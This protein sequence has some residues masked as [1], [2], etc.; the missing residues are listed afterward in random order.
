M[1]ATAYNA[2]TAY[3]QLLPSLKGFASKL[4][5]QLAE[6]KETVS[7]GVKADTSLLAEEIRAA[8]T[9]AAE[10]VRIDIPMGVDPTGLRSEIEA[11][12]ETATA[13]LRVD[14]GIGVDDTG[15]RTRLETAISNASSGLSA[16]I[17]VDFD[18]EDLRARLAAVTGLKVR[19]ELDP[20]I[21][22]LRALL[23]ALPPIDVRVDL[24]PDLAALRAQL[25]AAN[26]ST[27]LRVDVDKDGSG[28]SAAGGLSRILKIATAAVAAL[29][30]SGPAFLAPLISALVA[31]AGAAGLLP[32]A[33]AAAG[34]SF[35]AIKIGVSGVGDA[36]KALGA[37]QEASGA[38][39]S[40]NAAQQAAAAKAI[41]DAARG[42]EDAQ[43]QAD[44]TAVDGARQVQDARQG[45][46]DAMLAS[47]ERVAAAE[48]RVVQAQRTRRFAQEDLTRAIRDAKEAQE[49]LTLSLSGAALSEE[50]AL[51]GLER[52]RERLAAM[53]A[54][55]TALD[56]KEA[57]LAV[58]QA[59]QAVR[60]TAERHVDL[61][62]ESAESAR[63]GIA[64][65]R[66]V[67]DANRQ[68]TDANRG[69]YDAESEL[70]QARMEGARDVQDAN[71]QLALA[72]E[73]AA[74]AN[75]DAARAVQRAQE[76]L[77]E[78][79][80]DTGGAADAAGD[81]AAAALAKLAPAAR[82]YVAAI[83]ALRP[84]WDSLK[85]DVQQALFQGLGASI[86]QLANAQLP[87]LASGLSGIAAGFNAAARE[88]F[89]FL[90][91]SGAVADVKQILADSKVSTDAWAMSLVPISAMFLDIAAVGAPIL[92]RLSEG[93]LAATERAAAFIETA[94][95]N[96]DLARWIEGGLQALRD[97]GEFL[98]NIAG[99]IGAVFDAMKT[100]GTS[101]MDTLILVTGEME[102]FLKSP[103]GQEFLVTFFSTL[104]G[105][106]QA[107][108]PGIQA[109]ATG[110]AQ[111]FVAFA[112]A[113]QPIA[114]AISAVLDA[115]SPLLPVVAEIAGFLG[116][117][118]AEAIIAL[119]P[120]LR[121]IADVVSTVL[122]TAF[123]ALKPVFVIIVEA[124][125]EMAPVLSEIARG[126]GDLLVAAIEAIA[127]ILPPLAD[128]FFRIMEALLP[129]LPVLVEFAAQLID[130]LAPILPQLTDLFI[131]VIDEAI[132]P[133]IPPLLRL[134]QELFPMLLW[135]I[136]LLLPI[137]VWLVSKFVDD[138]VW[139]VEN[140]V[141][142]A[143]EALT[144]VFETIRT[145]WSDVGA[146][147]AAKWLEFQIVAEATFYQIKWTIERIWD[148]IKTKVFETWT[149]IK[150]WFDEKWA[151]FR[152][153]WDGF[154]QGVRD[155][156]FTKWAEIKAD[157]TAAWETIRGF[158][159]ERLAEFTE[160]WSMIW[161]GIRD[162]FGVT[163]VIIRD[164]AVNAWNGIAAF[165]GDAFARFTEFFSGVW[166]NI[167][168]FFAGVWVG[169][170]DT[171]VNA[172]NGIQAFFGG[173][174]AGFAAFFADTWNGIVSN[175]ST[176]WS[177][178]TDIA[179]QVW[180]NV[181]RGFVDGVN[182]VI[183]IINGF[184]G[185]INQVAGM[186]GFTINLGVPELAYAVGGP[187]PANVPVAGR[188]Q[189]TAFATGGA[190]PGYAPGRDTIP[191]MLSPGEY[192]I[193]PEAARVIGLDW[194]DQLN[195]AH[196]ARFATGGMVGDADRS[197]L[198]PPR[199]ALREM[200]ARRIVDGADHDGPGTLRSGFGGVRPHVA[201][202]GHF[203]RSKFGV[204]TVGGIG[205][206][207]GPS[208]HP[209]G[210]ALDFMTYDDTAKG[211]ALSN[212]VVSNAKH[213]A[214]KY[215]IWK[216][217]INSGG[218]WKGMED[219]GSVTANHFD[220]P[221]LSFLDLPGTGKDF[222]GGGAGWDP[223]G[224]IIRALLAPL[225][226]TLDAQK[227]DGAL[228]QKV[229]AGV[230]GKVLDH[231]IG[232]ADTQDGMGAGGG[233]PG[234]GAIRDQVRA[235]ANR[236]GWGGGPQWTAL[237][238]LV[239]KESSWDPN[240]QNPT[241]TAFG[242]F[243]FLNSTWGTVGATKTSNPG[244]QAEAGLRY[245]Q[246]RYR[247][248][249]GA[250][251]FHNRNNYYDEGGVA[252]GRGIMLKNVLS[253]ERVLSPR[254]NVAFE[255]LVSAATGGYRRTAQSAIG[256]DL[257]NA[258]R[259]AGGPLIGSLTVQA[260]DNASAKDI[261]DEAM[262]AARTEA[263]SGRYHR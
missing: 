195:R 45:V 41:R 201:Q 203:L 239:Q 164:T 113:I 135:A 208:D 263:R 161:T 29:G 56:Y 213:L 27:G 59:E 182:G 206:R 150:T 130:S 117:Y 23:A 151:E 51:L 234:S 90:S 26:L 84:A 116:I 42:V 61:Q 140:I 108:M 216:Q 28:R 105:A 209:R 159:A 62:Q 12:L 225:R 53:P 165:F 100:A 162:F 226:G 43:R 1:A 65:A 173:A 39:A 230:F 157:V 106:V 16:S 197:G 163:W 148:E 218:G 259:A 253:P 146:W 58:R 37:A 102:R 155:W 131:R 54:D 5:T 30:A 121:T 31:S 172:W 111:A 14:T 86:S 185:V 107:L 47:N 36:F 211:D 3:V 128:A 48:Q 73:S 247:T 120:F 81:K 134:A 136:E 49:D 11:A 66:G 87:G 207:S 79:Y 191:A 25:A 93:W 196:V 176:I 200:E 21:A 99:S 72:Q 94:R 246:Q 187:V 240:A 85:M 80:A 180:E 261:I 229:V 76:A 198:L 77:A 183:R 55:S 178:I 242:L 125:R 8:A 74:Q 171:A 241:S 214:L 143:I 132:L 243:Q 91:S 255:Q 168:M 228:P 194:L 32:A 179:R 212:Y 257:L 96:G 192:V 17:N 119:M 142:P 46:A 237:E 24:N 112:P 166:N 6:V 118:L 19:V 35:A 44:R 38:T 95:Q 63:V 20:D 217:R 249:V 245:I 133:L 57:E 205:Q 174:F 103:V 15:L 110:L 78:S 127:P 256:G 224:D 232:I 101:L 33:L 189:L 7:V 126:M 236:Y 186:L 221:H 10:N 262:W 92:G 144:A 220:H 170:T 82:E 202:A 2:G 235:V 223:V 175:F 258:D 222:D 251:D 147:I 231:V 115:L 184:A 233:A 139:T 244:L 122:M 64:G 60:E 149:E 40:A 98:G 104:Y 129:I 4:K 177:G 52:A 181:R 190:L 50:S 215:I 210:L 204:R 141:I 124:L 167:S 156:V 88:M 70:T 22:A 67:V 193:R 18:L 252:T 158:F 160:F 75:S 260:G 34:A 250:L 248:P 114:Q 71:T 238:R 254:Q 152:A 153:A 188:G 83:Q 227:R 123:E 219:R 69:V 154:W 68:L 199:R 9:T 145:I 109:V 89:G 97:L 137:I 138:L 169:L 13:G